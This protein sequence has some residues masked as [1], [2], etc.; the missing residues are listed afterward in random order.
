MLNALSID[1]E[2]YFQVEAFTRVIDRA[3]WSNFPRRVAENTRRVLRLLDAHQVRATFFILGWVA[4]REPELVREIAAGGHEIATHGYGH[5]LV[6]RQT[7]EE[8]AED[9]RRSIQ[10]IGDAWPD[11]EIQGYRAPSFSITLQSQWALDILPELGIR[12][13]SSIFPMSGHDLY[14]IPDALALPIGSGRNS[15]SF[16]SVRC[17]MPGGIGP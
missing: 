9:V 13:D 15:A 3:D 10:V 8:F 4:Q 2:D 5:R 1:V 14:G 11:A 16:P 12:Y 6:Y 17:A 7:P